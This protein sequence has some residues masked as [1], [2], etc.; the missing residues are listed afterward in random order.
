MVDICRC[1]GEQKEE[2]GKETILFPLSSFIGWG[3]RRVFRGYTSIIL[4]IEC[5][6]ALGPL[7]L[8]LIICMCMVTFIAMGRVDNINC[9]N[10]LSD[11]K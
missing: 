6:L 9:H 3:Q 5:G 2:R 4:E 7:I 1:L 11:L 10:T 8:F